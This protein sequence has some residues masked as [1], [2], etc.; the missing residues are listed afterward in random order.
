L[1]T[2]NLLFLYPF[3]FRKFDWDRFECEYLEKEYNIKIH[4]HEVI[5]FVHPHFQKAYLSEMQENRVTRFKNIKDWKKSFQS[6]IKVDP[7]MLICN[8]VKPENFSSL[9]ICLELKK[10]NINDFEWASIKMPDKAIKLNEKIL[11][12]KFFE[13]FLNPISIKYFLSDKFFKFLGNLFNL[14][15]KYFFKSGTEHFLGPKNSTIIRGNAHDYSNYLIE[16][17]NFNNKKVDRVTALY[18]EKPGPMFQGDNLLKKTNMS[19]LFTTEKWYPSLVK[20]FDRLED[21]LKLKIK[22]APHPKTKHKKFPSY[23]GKREIID[24]RLARE[25]FFAKIII[26]IDSTGLCFSTLHNIPSI[27][28]YSDELNRNK[29]WREKQNYIADKLGVKPVNIDSKFDG[30]LIKNSLVINE[31]K[32]REYKTKYL[33]SRNDQKLNY[34]ILS[35]IELNK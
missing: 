31:E 23:Y 25:S 3:K 8:E 4:I 14:K 21:L 13:F 9:M 2:K 26:S 7:N 16:K 11:F 35:N 12:T 28:I 19:N 15:P 27:M 20:F 18:L 24:N 1:K 10:Y 29:I 30:N 17:K 5:D 33:T 6:L 22:I 32:Y 34:Q